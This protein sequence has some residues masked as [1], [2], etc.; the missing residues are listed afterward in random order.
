MKVLRNAVAL[1][2]LKLGLY[3]RLVIGEW[4]YWKV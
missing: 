2:R 1:I 4:E 3:K